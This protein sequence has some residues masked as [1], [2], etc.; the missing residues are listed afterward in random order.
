MFDK[1]LRTSLYVRNYGQTLRSQR[2]FIHV[3]NLIQYCEKLAGI[4]RNQKFQVGDL[5]NRNN[6]KQVDFFFSRAIPFI[7][8][9]AI[10][11]FLITF[12]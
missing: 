11:C 12:F 5:C 4:P 9:N 8:K 1:V 3:D 6:V 2:L 10:Q 7:I